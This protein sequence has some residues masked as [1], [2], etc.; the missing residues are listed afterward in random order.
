MLKIFLYSSPFHSCVYA[1]WQFTPDFRPKVFP[2][3]KRWLE[4]TLKL[5]RLL[6]SCRSPIEP[7]DRNVSRPEMKMQNIC[8]G[9]ERSTHR[10]FFIRLN[11]GV[12]AT[13]PL[14]KL[15]LKL[16]FQ[17]KYALLHFN[18]G[19][20]DDQHPPGYSSLCLCAFCCPLM[21]MKKHECTC[22]RRSSYWR[23][24]AV[25]L[26]ALWW[27]WQGNLGWGARASSVSSVT[28][29]RRTGESRRDSPNIQ[30][31]SMSLWVGSQM[32]HILRSNATP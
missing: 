3:H 32:I 25:L 11:T 2:S 17:A 5:W 30:T 18:T 14:N 8:Q 16:E 19:R 26:A 24:R 27:L 12:T 22:L 10:C 9:G 6:A 29:C 4:P 28:I 13:P 31:W 7:D 20:L 21:V 1:L 15:T 23:C